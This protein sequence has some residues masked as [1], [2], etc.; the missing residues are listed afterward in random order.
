MTL[1]LKTA[2]MRLMEMLEK[3]K[4]LGLAKLSN[5]QLLHVFIFLRNYKIL[6]RVKTILHHEFS[7][8][9]Y[10]PRYNTDG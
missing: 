1:N 5:N 3:E 6:Y 4:S 9:V 7:I 10:S 8:L 2:R